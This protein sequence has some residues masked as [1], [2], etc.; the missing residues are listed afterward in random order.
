MKLVA[1]AGNLELER[2]QFSRFF[3]YSK[4]YLGFFTANQ[5]PVIVLG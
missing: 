4:A 1:D 2:I 3:G 5:T